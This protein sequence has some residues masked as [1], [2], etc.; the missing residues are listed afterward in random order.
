M[1]TAAAKEMTKPKTEAKK[2]PFLLT[3]VG[4]KYVMGVTGLIWAGFVLT[5]MAGNLLLLISPDAYNSYG[6]ALTSG[7]IIYPAEIIILLA[8]IVHVVCAISLVRGNLAARGGVQRY[9]MPTNGKKR[10]SIFSKTMAWQGSIILVFIITHI[11]TFK[12]GTYYE[13]T[14]NGVVMR[15]LYRLIVEVFR[16]PGFVLWYLVALVLLGFHLSHG[17]WSSFQS[18]GIKNDHFVPWIRKLSIAYAIIVAAG[19]LVQPIYVY[20]LA[21]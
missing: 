21:K 18:L 2:I 15:D 4:K 19:F 11:S 1:T 9:A 17:V 20:F 8:L 14:V 13:T 3:T 10:A 5:H 12:Y 16:Q 7:M 6:H